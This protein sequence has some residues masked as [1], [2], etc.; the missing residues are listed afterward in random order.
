M[1]QRFQLRFAQAS[2]SKPIVELI[3]SVYREYN[4]AVCLAGAEADLVDLDASYFDQTGAFWVL[5]RIDELTGNCEIVGTH[6]A[7]SDPE[8]SDVCVFRRLY[9]AAGLR[10][11]MWGHRLMQTTIDWTKEQ[12]FKRVEFWSD[13]RFSRAHRFFEK[14]GFVRDG[15][16]RQMFDGN[17]PYQEYFYA[18]DLNQE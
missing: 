18:L 3:D 1:S 5:E 15:R 12:G 16:V 14:F 7:T 4:D 2:D 9:L 17:D 8:N 6:A 13:T 11:S 10:G